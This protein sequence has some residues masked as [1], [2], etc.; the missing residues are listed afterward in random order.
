MDHALAALNAELARHAMPG[1]IDL[2]LS[3]AEQRRCL[4]LRSVEGRLTVSAAVAGAVDTPTATIEFATA[5]AVC[6]MLRWSFWR[7]LQN[8]KI[9]KFAILQ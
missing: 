3:C 9:P 2:E 1:G 7:I 4:R 5:D 8:C 6:L